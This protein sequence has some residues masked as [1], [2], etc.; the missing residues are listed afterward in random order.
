MF[1]FFKKKSLHKRLDD[2][3]YMTRAT[4]N[5]AFTAHAR[6]LNAE[7]KAVLL[8]FFEGSLDQ[9]KKQ[10]PSFDL[11]MLKAEKLVNDLSVRGSVKGKNAPTL[12]FLEHHPGASTESSVIAAIEELFPDGNAAIGFYAGL[13]EPLM[14]RFG[15]DKIIE[16][17]KK[18]GMKDD[19]AISHSMV[20]ASIKRAQEKISAKVSTEMSANSQEEWMNVNGVTQTN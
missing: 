13:D 11:P 14:K 17:M 7:N 9:L 20:T 2:K 6:Q 15:S 16:L 3:I 8:Y 4:A 10:D 18:M 1:G 5:A 12:L 19:E